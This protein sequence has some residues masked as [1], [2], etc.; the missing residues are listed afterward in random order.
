[1]ECF[2]VLTPFRPRFRC[3]IELLDEMRRLRG[4]CHRRLAATAIGP[5]LG[6]AKEKERIVRKT[7]LLVLLFGDVLGVAP[8][9]F[10]QSEMKPM[11]IV[12]FAGYDGLKANVDLIGRLSGTP[13]SPKG[14]R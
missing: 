6:S 12:S 4:G 8:L 10:A 11:A 7:L 13:N 2:H 1:M 9:C 14:W 5:P 3:D